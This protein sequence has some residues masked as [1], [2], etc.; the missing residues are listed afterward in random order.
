VTPDNPRT[1]DPDQITKEVISGFHS[2]RH[3]VFTDRSRG[4]KTALSRSTKG[5][6]VVVLGK[7]REEYQDIKGEKVFHSDLAIIQDYQ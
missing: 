3:T 6:V 2:D 5:D 4:L 7:G 1:E